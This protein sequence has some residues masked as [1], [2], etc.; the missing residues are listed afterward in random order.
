M[1]AFEALLIA[2]AILGRVADDEPPY[3]LDVLLD[4]PAD[5]WCRLELVP[6][7]GGSTVSLTVAGAPSDVGVL[8]VR[9]RFVAELNLLDWADDG[10]HRRQPW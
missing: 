10:P 7:G 1:E 2:G 6:D 8:E 9:D 3:R 5:T 4:E